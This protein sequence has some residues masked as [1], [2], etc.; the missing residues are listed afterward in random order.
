M[1]IGLVVECTS[2][3]L[4]HCVCPKIL[5]LLAEECGMKLDCDA[6]DNIILMVNREVTDPACGRGDTYVVGPR[7]SADCILVG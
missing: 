4:E 3:G 2:M 6:H 1:R 5:R 7:M